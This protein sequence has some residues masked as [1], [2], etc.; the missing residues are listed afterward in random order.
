MDGRK[1]A[2][3][4]YSAPKIAAPSDRIVSPLDIF[5]RP[6]T[7]NPQITVDQ[8]LYCLESQR[9][10]ATYGVVGEV[11][12]RPAQSVGAALGTRRQRA[13]WVVNA[14]T[15][16]PT[17]YDPSEKHPDLYHTSRIIRTADEL[18][19][20]CAKLGRANTRSSRRARLV[21]Q[22]DRNEDFKRS[23][24][25]EPHLAVG[26]DGCSAGWVFVEVRPTGPLR[27]GVVQRLRELVPDPHQSA[28]VFV[29]IPI[30]LPD[31]RH[32]RKCDREARRV[33]GKRR[34]SV[35]RVPPRAVLTADNYGYANEVSLMESG[36]GITKQAYGILDKCRE[37][38]QL[39]RDYPAVR[40]V[41]REIHPEI[42]FWA[43]AGRKPMQHYKKK[44]EGFRERLDVLKRVRPSAA[45]EIE[46]TLAEF[47][48]RGRDVARDDVVDAMAAALTA[49]AGAGSLRT[50]P[51]KPPRDAF[52]LPME[53]VYV[54]PDA[55]AP[56]L[57]LIRRASV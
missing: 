9:I 13:S 20:L 35:F 12:G 2:F 33:L 49:A 32:E 41:I 19:R 54:A 22:A 47:N 34:S 7:R 57:P 44:G 45:H 30:G 37:V 29:D 31:G 42:C 8:I 6:L 11:I 17:D 38:D 16:E 4:L 1:T 18:R 10:R 3:G 53:M 21:A 39:L 24:D 50:L 56:K 26:V 51:A 55:T 14:R 15:R 36:A 28:R 48:P 52:G 46:R 43:F 23:S 27:Y 25:T 5:E 40:A